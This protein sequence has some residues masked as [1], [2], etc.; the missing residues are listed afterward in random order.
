MLLRLD[1]LVAL[2]LSCWQD[3]HLLNHRTWPSSTLVNH[4]APLGSTAVELGVFI[5]LPRPAPLLLFVS[6]TQSDQ[7]AMPPSTRS[8]LSVFSMAKL[9]A[10]EQIFRR[11]RTPSPDPRQDGSDGALNEVGSHFA[12]DAHTVR[13]ECIKATDLESTPEEL[14]QT[15]V[16]SNTTLHPRSGGSG[17]GHN[18]TSSKS[19]PARALTPEER[20]PYLTAEEFRNWKFQQLGNRRKRSTSCKC[21]VQAFHCSDAFGP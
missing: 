17:S 6:S 20:G 5:L 7:A 14:K 13:P 21:L 16:H 9:Y 10:R 1:H 11:T 12:E 3:H 19:P 8:S 4:L 18:D 2:Y 15:P